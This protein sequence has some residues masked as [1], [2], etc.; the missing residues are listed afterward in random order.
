MVIC[1]ALIRDSLCT[2][3]HLQNIARLPI[4]K[5][6]L[7][8]KEPGAH[9]IT[10]VLDLDETLVHCS[11]DKNSLPDAEINFDVVFQGRKFQVYVQK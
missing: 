3:G 7:P 2:V 8:P 4:Q 11:T 9:K 6:A 5:Y 10:L 1:V